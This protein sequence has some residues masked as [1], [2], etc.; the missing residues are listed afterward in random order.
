MAGDIRSKE[1]SIVTLT[2]T[3]ASLTN[4]S[5][6]VANATADLDARSGG[7][8]ADD[9]NCTF[10]LLVQ[11]ATITGIVAGTVIG[12]LYLVPLVDGTNLP[13]VDL[14]AGSSR[15][16][17]ASYVAPFD[18]VKAPTANT[19]MRFITAPISINPLLY[20]PYLLNKSGQTMTANWDLK[21]VGVQG[22]YT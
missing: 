8:F 7:N 22:Q 6:A 12:E 11:W 16:P 2:L 15:L 14:T 13:D 9:F 17:Y 4:L 5:A 18:A 19:D 10:E 21:A 20:R 3:G 1:R